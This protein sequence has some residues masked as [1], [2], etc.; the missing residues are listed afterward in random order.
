[1]STGGEPKKDTIEELVRR[2]RAGQ[3][4]P[5]ATIEDLVKLE[6]DLKLRQIR[7]ITLD[8]VL[9]KGQKELKEIKESMG[10]GTSGGQAQAQTHPPELATGL[11]NLLIRDAAV[12]KQWVELSEEQRNV[13]LQSI[14]MLTNAGQSGQ[15]AM[16]FPI[17]MAS[18]RGNPQMNNPMEL[19][20]TTIEIMK[21]V[22]QP[23]SQ[24]G[25]T[26]KILEYLEKIKETKKPEGEDSVLKF[27]VEQTK[28]L[29]EQ[30]SQARQLSIQKDLEEL[31]NRPSAVQEL[32]QKKDELTALQ[33]LFGPPAPATTPPELQVKLKEMELNQARDVKEKEWDFLRWQ[34]D[35]MDKKASQ[36][37]NMK[38]LQQMYGPAM[39]Q[40]GKVLDALSQGASVGRAQA[41]ATAAAPRVT[42]PFTFPCESCGAEITIEKPP[43]PASVTCPKCG[44]VLGARPA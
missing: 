15:A 11:V 10:E 16:L 39:Q 40:L 9:L 13:L 25:E 23:Q 18:V 24:M 4:H 37:R 17:M 12:Q 28:T 29:M 34:T 3:Q 26:L 22:Q 43:L 5:K 33:S 36:D 31:K 41:V 30:L 42:F 35:R 2:T 20:K 27:F 19:V 14:M 1:M 21:S 44:T 38:L 8:K 6:D 7:D 32:A